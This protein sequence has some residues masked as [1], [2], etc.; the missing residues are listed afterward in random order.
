MATLEER[1]STVALGH[2]FAPHPYPSGDVVAR[3]SMVLSEPGVTVLVAEA[4][5]ALVGYAAFDRASL[6]HLAVAPE[7]FGTGLADA[8]HEG[9]VELWRTAGARHVEL[10]V[11]AANVRARRFYERHGWT[12]DGRSQECPWPPYPMEVGYARELA[13]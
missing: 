3:W 13:G 1:S 10:W 5:G 9:A 12:A 6:R 11:L 2:L 8:L 4:G 7:H